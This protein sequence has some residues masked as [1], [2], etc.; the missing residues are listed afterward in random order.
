MRAAD[1]GWGC[2]GKKEERKRR[3]GESKAFASLGPVPAGKLAPPDSNEGLAPLRK[4]RPLPGP[5]CPGPSCWP[6]A[7]HF[8][9]LREQLGVVV[10]VRFLAASP[11]TTAS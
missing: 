6:R 8:A 7:S 5:S 10:K 9:T 1:P 4:D 11:S 3:K 2:H